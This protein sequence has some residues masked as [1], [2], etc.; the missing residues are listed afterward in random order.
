MRAAG[1]PAAGECQRRGDGEDASFNCLA[2]QSVR[3]C[4]PSRTA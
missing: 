1:V 3:V 2:V 4:V